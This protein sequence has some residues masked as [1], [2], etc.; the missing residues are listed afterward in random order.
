MPQKSVN[1]PEIKNEVPS[2]EELLAYL[3]EWLEFS[4][5]TMLTGFPGNQHYYHPETVEG[6]SYLSSSPICSPFVAS[7]R[8]TLFDS[9][10]LLNL[11]PRND[12]FWQ[13][14][15]LRPTISKLTD[16]GERVM[17]QEPNDVSSLLTRAILDVAHVGEFEPRRWVQL[18]LLG[19]VDLEFVTFAAMLLE[20]AGS[21]NADQSGSFI[22]S[23]RTTSESEAH[24]RSIRGRGGKLLGAWS[25]CVAKSLASREL[26]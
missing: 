14:T 11:L 7:A 9:L 21:P 17:T 12:P 10:R 24:L 2:N 6:L 3:D 22:V 13:N 19:A 1:V 16:Y 5:F 4:A 8:T 15:N 20:V 18:Y 26:F 23:T 25:D